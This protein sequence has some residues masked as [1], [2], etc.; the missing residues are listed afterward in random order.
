MSKLQRQED[1]M[2]EVA[3]TI[4]VPRLCRTCKHHHG[5]IYGGV[6]LVCAVHPYGYSG[7]SCPDRD[8]KKNFLS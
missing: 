8:C 6:E 4:E 3:Y 1:E 2:Y 5:Q 7:D